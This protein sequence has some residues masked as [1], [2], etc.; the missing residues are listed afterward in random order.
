MVLCI[1][2][3]VTERQLEAAIEGGAHTLAEIA[4]RLGAGS[5]CGC[6]RDEIEERLE[7]RGPCGRACAG[8]PRGS[9]EVGSAA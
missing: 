6:C 3:A 4:E 5:D 9:V 2:R 1:C 7:S 8:C